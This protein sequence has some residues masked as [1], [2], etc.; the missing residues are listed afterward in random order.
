MSFA[1]E[2]ST[3][4]S[5]ETARCRAR[6]RRAARDHLTRDAAALGGAGPDRSRVEHG[7]TTEEL[8][9]IKA[10]RREVADQQRTI[11]TATGI[12]I[13]FCDPH[14][15][16]QRGSNEN[17]NGLLRQYLHKAPTSRSSLPPTSSAASQDPRLHDTIRGLHAGRC[18]HRLN[19][20]SGKGDW[21]ANSNRAG[22]QDVGVDADAGVA[23]ARSKAVDGVVLGDGA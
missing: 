1:A 7:P 3:K 5:S 22:D 9:E 16:W 6:G 8:A 4:S 15:P 21:L 2:R 10:L 13:Y 11:E 12:P 14:A 23:D 18:G 20:P 19:P 17:T